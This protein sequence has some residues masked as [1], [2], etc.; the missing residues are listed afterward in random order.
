MYDSKE[1]E[2]LF[3]KPL[4]SFKLLREKWPFFIKNKNDGF[5]SLWG[6]FNEYI[7]QNIITAVL[8]KTKRKTDSNF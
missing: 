1:V 5:W 6:I 2:N 4:L 7:K 8:R 3:P